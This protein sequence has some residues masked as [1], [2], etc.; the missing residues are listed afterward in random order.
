MRRQLLGSV[1][2]LLLASTCAAMTIEVKGPE[3][4][5]S[6]GFFDK[7]TIARVQAQFR[8]HKNL[9]TVVLRDIP[10]G[11]ASAK[12]DVGGRVAD[13]DVVINGLCMSA[14]AHI[15]LNAKRIELGED[16]LVFIHGTFALD[17]R[18]WLPSSLENANWISARLPTVDPAKIIEALSFK[19]PNGEGMAIY[20]RPGDTSGL[21][22]VMLCRPMPTNCRAVRYLA[23]GESPFFIGTR[24]RPR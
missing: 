14:C 12:W 21:V 18:A 3:L 4:H 2:A 10:G 11:L 5:L 16:A 19:N 7:L 9:T 23:P 20:V 17:T 6:T 1:A 15:A 22:A 24:A 13:K 8:E